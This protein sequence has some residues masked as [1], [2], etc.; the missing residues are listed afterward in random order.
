MLSGLF[1]WGAGVFMDRRCPDLICACVLLRSCFVA[2]LIVLWVGVLRCVD[3]VWDLFS[4]TVSLTLYYLHL[5]V[6]TDSFSG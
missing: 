3:G 6:S 5:L 1:L 4:S 2:V